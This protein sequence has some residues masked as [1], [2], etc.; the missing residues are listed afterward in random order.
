MTMLGTSSQALREMA[1]H[2]EVQAAIPGI[3]ADTL[4]VHWAGVDEP[5]YVIGARLNGLDDTAPFD[6]MKPS[7]TTGY[8]LATAEQFTNGELSTAHLKP[9][10]IIWQHG[11]QVG[12]V[13][14][15][16]PLG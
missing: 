14:D 6:F 12:C 10:G 5:L 2:P 15:L 3:L 8:A 9:S 11:V 13:F 16:E 1:Q 4:R 7:L